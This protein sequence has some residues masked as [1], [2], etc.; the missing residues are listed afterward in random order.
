MAKGYIQTYGVDY[1]ETFAHVAKINIVR[2]LFS[3]VM[4]LGCPL[5]QFDVKNAFPHGEF[6]Y[7][8]YMELP[9]RLMILGIHS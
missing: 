8:V 4:N 2:V 6:S 5:Q 3:L 1:T 7:E 9:P